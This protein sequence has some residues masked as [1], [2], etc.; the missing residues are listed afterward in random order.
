MIQ[1]LLNKKVIYDHIKNHIPF[2]LDKL[3]KLITENEH[4]DLIETL[5]TLVDSFMYEITPYSKNM[6]R[7]LSK[8]F[9]KYSI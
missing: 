3:L 1:K 9:L 5:E 6:I 7:E 2:L 8:T 4:E